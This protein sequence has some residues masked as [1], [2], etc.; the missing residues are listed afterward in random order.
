MA[1]YK[2]TLSESAEL[3]FLNYLKTLSGIKTIEKI[4]EVNS[5][6]KWQDE[7]VALRLKEYLNN[8]NDVVDLENTLKELEKDL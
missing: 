6:P 4:E 5:I 8:P 3:N 7:E 1:S 2:I